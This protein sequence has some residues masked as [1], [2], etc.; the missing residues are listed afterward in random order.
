MVSYTVGA[1]EGGET[2]LETKG[3]MV[4]DVGC[5]CFNNLY[6]EWPT[7]IASQ[8]EALNDA[9]LKYKCYAQFYTF[10][11]GLSGLIKASALEKRRVV[12][13]MGNKSSP[14]KDLA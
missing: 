7:G 10:R 5:W 6:G 8:E 9:F 14:H 1:E 3:R 4:F 2:Y 11:F 12:I 13:M